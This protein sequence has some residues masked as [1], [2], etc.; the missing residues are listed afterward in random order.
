[1]SIMKSCTHRWE[2]VSE[3]IETSSY[4]HSL[5]MLQAV[6]GEMSN[7]NQLNQDGTH[8]LILTCPR[9]GKLD[10]TVTKI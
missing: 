1:M 4:K 5:N 2:I 6:G 8:I 9:C 10:K 7:L 3:H